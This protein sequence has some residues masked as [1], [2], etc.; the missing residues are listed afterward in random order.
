MN[1]AGPWRGRRFSVVIP[2]RNRAKTLLS[3]LQTCV[4]QSFSNF[5]IVICDN[6]STPETRAVVEQ[7]NSDKIIY[8]GSPTQLS[9][10]DNWNLATTLAS[11]EFITIIGD[12][13]ALMPYAFEQLDRVLK[14]T[15]V[16]A[17]RWESA[18]YAWPD[19]ARPELANYLQIPLSRSYEFLNGRKTIGEVLNA[20]TSGPTLPNIYHGMVANSL[21]SDIRKK[22]GR[23]FGSHHCDTYSSFA[24]AYHVGKY[25][26][27]ST[28][29]SIQGFS[30]ASNNIAFNSM[31]RKST[32]GQ[33]YRVE[34]AGAP[35]NSLIP[36]LPTHYVV[37]P[38]S[39]LA[40]KADLFPNDSSLVLDRKV[41]VN[42][43]LNHM[44]ID[45]IDE[46]PAAVA[47]IRRAVSDDAELLAWFELRL[48]NT[49]PKT[50]PRDSLRPR[51]MGFSN[52]RLHLDVKKRGI[53]N[54]AQAAQLAAQIMSAGGNNLIVEKEGFGDRMLRKLK[55]AR[56][57]L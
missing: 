54:V 7:L 35:V 15:N 34:S 51:F 29:M 37:L 2:T 36:D 53:T 26:S 56:F 55:V 27:L 38:E 40:A 23:V 24:V 39:F 41:L 33:N 48:K 32:V 31:R 6:F 52:G 17:L 12:D 5:E 16:L 28:P 18:L 45:T 10:A 9:M 42:Q 47:E 14:K 4:A 11:G 21:L 57:V 22:T 50:S 30:G 46:W 19:I 1:N 8:H 20:R 3:T 49:K 43:L 44:P 13:D 25:L